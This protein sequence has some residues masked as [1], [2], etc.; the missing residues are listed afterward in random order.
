MRPWRKAA[1]KAKD[2]TPDEDAKKLISG[3]LRAGLDNLGN[4]VK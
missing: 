4:V 2:G 1:R 3:V